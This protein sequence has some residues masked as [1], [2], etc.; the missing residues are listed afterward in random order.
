MYLDPTPNCIILTPGYGLDQNIR[1]NE[2]TPLIYK[3][4][5]LLVP[6][7]RHRLLKKKL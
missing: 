2:R 3:V 4:I 6:F 1:I 7:Y 5:C